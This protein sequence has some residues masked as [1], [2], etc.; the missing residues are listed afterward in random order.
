[1]LADRD[2]RLFLVTLVVFHFA[3]LPAMSLA[4]LYMESLGASNS[5]IAFLAFIAQPGMIVSAWLAGRYGL[6]IGHKTL[7]VISF[8]VLPLRMLLYVWAGDPQ[9][10][11][12]ITVLDGVGSGIFGVAVVL[13]CNDLTRRGTG[14]NSLLGLMCAAPSMGA[15]TGSAVKG[16][17][18]QRFGFAPTFLFFATVAIAITV[19]FM[20]RMRES[21][22][23]P[24]FK[25]EAQALN[26]V[27]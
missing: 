17:I 8:L 3:S 19:Y 15:V 13:I 12:L 11:L 16:V 20:V 6:R 18:L 5:Q 7:L 1:L 4:S 27:N 9:T 10:V 14:F 25:S 2:V 21:V 26:L 24:D 22:L 23:R